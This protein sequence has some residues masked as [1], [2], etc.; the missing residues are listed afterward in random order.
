MIYVDFKAVAEKI[1]R[2]QQNNDKSY[3]EA[4][5]KL[6]DSGYEYKVVCC[7]DDQNSKPVQIYRGKN[8]V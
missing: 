4:Y 7:Y 1:Q 2:C 6:T 5:K 3:T 8:A